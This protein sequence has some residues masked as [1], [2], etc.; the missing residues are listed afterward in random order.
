VLLFT[1]ESVL[2]RMKWLKMTP[3]VLKLVILEYAL[4]VNQLIIKTNKRRR[5]NSIF[6]QGNKVLGRRTKQTLKDVLT[7]YC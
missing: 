1:F 7:I 4:I 2:K 3:S 5:A 6:L